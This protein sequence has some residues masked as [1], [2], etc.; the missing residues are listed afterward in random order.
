MADL[1]KVVR[2]NAGLEFSSDNVKHF[3]TYAADLTHSLDSLR[4]QYIDL[5]SIQGVFG[6][7]DASL[8]PVRVWYGLGHWAPRRE[9]IDGSD[10][11]GEGVFREGIVE[12]CVT[13][14]RLVCRLMCVLR[15]MAVSWAQ[16]D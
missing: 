2:G 9:G 13:L 14:C 4:V 6:L 7:R 1:V 8:S 12:P 11:A 15:M 5:V 10:G 3:P 16:C